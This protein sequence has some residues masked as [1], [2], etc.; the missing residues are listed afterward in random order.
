M[1]ISICNENR[2]ILDELLGSRESQCL[3]IN[4]D[5]KLLA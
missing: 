1:F 4:R 5:W 3:L 2:L